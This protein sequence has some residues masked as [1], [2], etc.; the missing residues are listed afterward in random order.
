MKNAVFAIFAVKA[1]CQAAFRRS[2]SLAFISCLKVA[3]NSVAYAHNGK[4]LLGSPKTR[5][6]SGQAV[7]KFR[8]KEIL[9]C[10]KISSCILRKFVLYYCQRS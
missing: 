5:I 3:S 10:L 4:R 8:A 2:V 1:L 9:I 6:T 7:P